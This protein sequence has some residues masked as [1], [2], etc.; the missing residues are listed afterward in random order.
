MSILD[1]K[2]VPLS[3]LKGWTLNPRGITTEGYSRLLKQ[4][5]TLGVYAPLLINQDNI[6]LSG[7]MRLKAFQEIGIDPVDVWV[8]DAQ[9]QETMTKYALSANDRAGYYDEQQLAELVINIPKIELGDYHVDLGK[10]SD[11]KQLLSNFGDIV[12]TEDRTIS[13]KPQTV[14][15]PE[16]G[17]SFEV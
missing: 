14:T 2:T 16:C 5:K 3:T 13:E 11:L 1:K 10:T 15:C 4:I 12:G 7:N 6:V 17:H 8:V 9:D